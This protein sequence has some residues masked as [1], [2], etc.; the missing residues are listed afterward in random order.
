MCE[1]LINDYSRKGFFDGRSVR[2]PTVIIRPGRPNTA[3]SSWASGMF[4]EPLN[5][6]TCILPVKK[7]QCHPMTGYRTVVES[8]LAI[9]ELPTKCFRD[10]R[11]IGL[12]AHQVTPERAETVLREVAHELNLSLGRIVEEFDPRIQAIV[13]SWPTDIDGTRAIQLGLPKP[14]SLRDIVL[15]YVADFGCNAS[16]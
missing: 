4:R 9:H 8:L 3:A 6:E 12:P 13:S 2:L 1:M 15:Q 5:G 10:D 14:P 16:R 11:A 7:D